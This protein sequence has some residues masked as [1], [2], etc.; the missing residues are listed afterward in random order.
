MNE[1]LVELLRVKFAVYL[2]I[3]FTEA[4]LLNRLLQY[5]IVGLELSCTYPGVVAFYSIYSV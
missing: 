4:G 5:I 3:L 1:V 2:N